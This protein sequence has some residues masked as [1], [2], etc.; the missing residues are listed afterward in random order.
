MTSDLADSRDRPDLGVE[1]GGARKH[2]HEHVT[3]MV[4]ERVLVDGVLHFRHLAQVIYVET[5]RLQRTKG[6]VLLKR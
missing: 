5:L 3:E 6:A 1:V 4:E 2:V